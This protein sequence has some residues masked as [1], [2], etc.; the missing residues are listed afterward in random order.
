[1]LR[2]IR[3]TLAA[4][5]LTGITLLFI[6]VGAQWWGWMAKLQFLPSC[7]ALNFLVIGGI[8]LITLLFERIYCSVICPLGVFQDL[9]LS[10]RQRIGKKFRKQHAF[11]FSREHK[12]L[13]YGILALF[14]VALVAGAQVLVALIAPYS[15]YGRIVSSIAGIGGGKP[16]ALTITGLVTMVV[17]I[18][19]AATHGRAWCNNICPVGTVLGLFSRFA[20]FRPMIDGSK[21]VHCHSCGKKCKSG[22]ID[23]VNQKIDCSRCVDCFDCIGNCKVGAIKYKFAYGE[24]TATVSTPSA[25][26]FADPTASGS[27]SYVAEGGTGLR[28]GDRCV[29][30]KSAKNQA[31]S[32]RR[33][34][35][36]RDGTGFGGNA[37][38]ATDNTVHKPEKEEHD[39]GR[40]NF[41]VTAATLVGTAALGGSAIAKAA[42]ASET[43]AEAAGAEPLVPFGARSVKH[44]YDR[45]TACQLCVQNCPNGVLRPST[46]L[47]HLLQ[48]VMAYDKG[49]CRP[50]CVKCS[51]ICPAGAILPV[52]KD[53]K[54]TIHIGVARVDL[55]LCVVKTDEVNCGNC[56]RH[57]PVG[58]IRLVKLEGTDRRIPTVYDERCIGCGACEHLCPAKPVK[59]IRVEGLAIHNKGRK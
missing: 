20:L 30:D 10:I 47:K 33:A 9:A 54:T 39:S 59:A 46:D 13:R 28:G 27:P 26:G 45:C 34:V 53:E 23:T 52:E 35:A 38:P 50:E 6:G 14:I 55:D 7:L 8:I 22:C 3:I 31:D 29:I 19:I 43:A 5:F 49:Y 2:K 36:H 11:S 40:R 21:C 37:R 32:S 48:P 42:E 58:A 17:I 56:A 18:A 24:R 12:I 4:L 16:A 41:I 1:M 51:E 44:F 57:C 25:V 15:A